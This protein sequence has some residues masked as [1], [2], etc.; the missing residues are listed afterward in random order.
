MFLA[1]IL[2]LA[3]SQLKPE[4]IYEKARPFVYTVESSEGTGTG[5]VSPGGDYLI[6]CDHVVGDDSTLQI[7]S[8]G[9]LVNKG[10][11]CRR[12]AKLDLAILA[13]ELPQKS[14][15]S[16]AKREPKVGQE[17]F[18]VGSSLGVLERSFTKGIVSGLRTLEGVGVLQFDAAISPGNS[19]GP[20][21]NPLGE[22]SGIVTS[23]ADRGQNVNL[24][25]KIL[26]VEALLKPRDTAS[27]QRLKLGN[28]GQ[29]KESV[30]IFKSKSPDSKALY[31][32]K[33]FQY[34]VVVGSDTEWCSILMA[35]GELGYLKKNAVT[36]LPEEY[37][38]SAVLASARSQPDWFQLKEQIPPD[39]T[40]FCESTA[41]TEKWTQNCLKFVQTVFKSAGRDIS[42]DLKVQKKVGS[43]VRMLEHLRA[44]DRLYFWQSDGVERAAI[45][46][47]DG[48]YTSVTKSGLV[49]TGAL[50]EEAKRQLVFAVRTTY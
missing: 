32:T 2:L 1:A 27:N 39:G 35:N 26:H 15:L 13:L 43:P 47:G 16:F 14:G 24:A 4:V 44:A 6:T 17:M 37:V 31:S 9:K 18:A 19:G 22:V 11:V 28:Y 10:F 45:Y 29:T 3:D 20:V 34:L 42:D 8:N 25:T 33:A 23:Y 21:L 49:V 48:R 46:R 12:D 38:V 30:E 36:I 40:T 7:T 41:L 50:D 5:F